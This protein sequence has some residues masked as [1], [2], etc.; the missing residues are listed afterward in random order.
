[1]STR[2]SPGPTKSSGWTASAASSDMSRLTGAPPKACYVGIGLTRE[3]AFAAID[4][5][6]LIGMALIST[7]FLLAL[8]AAWIGGR[9]FISRPIARLADAAGYW[10][11]GDFGVR[12]QAGGSDEI[13]V[14]A[15]TFNDM[16]AT[17]ADQQQE[18][19]ALLATL[20]ERVRGAHAGT[21]AR[22]GGTPPRRGAPCCKRRKWRRSGSSR[23]ASRMISTIF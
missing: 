10:R 14:L 12:V 9:H 18:N 16:A 3:T 4:R 13:G 23:G 6:T 15:N 8:A 22:G 1:M 21:G 5:A 19:A 20:E 7:G 11:R 17:L 2:P